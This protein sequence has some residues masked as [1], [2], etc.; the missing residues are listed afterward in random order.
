MRLYLIR[1]GET[2]WNLERRFQGTKDNPLNSTGVEQAKKISTILKDFAIQK[3]VASTLQRAQQTAEET[4]KV[5]GIPVNI[6]SNLHEVS[7]GEAE[8]MPTKELVEIFKD[9]YYDIEN[10]KSNDPAFDNMSYPGGEQKMSCRKRVFQAITSIAKQNEGKTTAVFFHGFCMRQFLIEVNKE[11]VDSV[12]NCE[13]IKVDFDSKKEEFK[14][15]DRIQPLQT[16]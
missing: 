12:K 5:I 9:P 11:P 15:L 16:S 14:I 6:V 4:S 3:I 1:H 13:I 10:W 2:D 8:G 7:V